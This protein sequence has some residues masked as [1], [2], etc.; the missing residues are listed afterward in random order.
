MKINR[1]GILGFTAAM[2]L[3][4]ASG[5]GGD[6]TGGTGGSAP[7]GGSIVFTASGEALALGGYSFPPAPGAEVAFVDGWEVKFTELIVTI[8]KITVSDNPDLDPGDQSRTGELV[9]QVDGPWA[10][11]LHKGGPLAGKGGSDEQAVELATLDKQNKNGDAPFAGDTRYAFGFDIVRATADATLVN[12]DDAGKADYEIMKQEGYAVLYVG[13]ATWKGGAGCTPMDPVFDAIPM[14]VNF[15]LGFKS[16]TTYGNCQNPDNDPAKAF[17][18]EEHLRGIV[19]KANQ[20]VTA[21]VTIHTDHPFWDSIQH[22]APPHFDQFAA[23]AKGATAEVTLEDMI[24]VDPT[25]LSDKDG[26]PLPW[27]TCTADFTP[28]DMGTMHFDTGGIPVNPGGDPATSFR[29]AYDYVTY[30]QST[31][32]H[33]NADG[34]CFV[35]RNYKSPP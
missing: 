19:V 17:E 7:G 10:V 24:G 26:N 16:P 15:K 33:M 11:D 5:C 29:D 35:K 21:Q 34:L 14:V 27:R 25:A 6:D 4:G 12:L 20:A 23:R 31:Q 30:G 8:D 18:G 9:A 2:A 28:P 22:D 3:F 1:A 13:T 32:G